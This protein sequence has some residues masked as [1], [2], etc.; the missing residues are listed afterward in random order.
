MIIKM[1]LKSFVLQ[2]TFSHFYV[3][4]STLNLVCWP[5]QC[6]LSQ[7]VNWV[8]EFKVLISTNIGHVVTNV[9]LDVNIA[10][11]DMYAS[12]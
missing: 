5:N 9:F 11:G 2:C 10:Y 8:K 3:D 1:A 7:Q 12:S 4:F 6:K